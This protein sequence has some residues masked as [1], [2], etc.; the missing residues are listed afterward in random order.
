MRADRSRWR[1]GGIERELG[2]MRTIRIDDAF[3]DAVAAA[4]EESADSIA[5]DDSHDAQD[6]A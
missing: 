1:D 2:K 4:H 3:R 6:P 5:Q